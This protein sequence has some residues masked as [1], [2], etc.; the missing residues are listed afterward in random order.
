MTSFYDWYADLPVASPQVFGD[1]T[2]VPESGDWWDATYLMMWGSNVP[3]T[4]TP[5]AHWMAEVRYRGT[6][7]VTR[8]PGLRRQHQVRRRVDARAGRHRRRARD[9]DG[10]RP[11]QAS[12][13]STAQVPFFHDY[14]RTYTDLPFLIRLDPRERDERLRPGQVPHRGRPRRRRAGRGRLEDRAAR[15][16]DRCAGRAQR[17]DGLPL[18]RVRRGPLEPRPRGVDPGALR[19]AGA[20]A[21]PVEVLLPAFDGAGRHRLGAAPRRARPTRRRAPGHDRLRPHARPVRRA[22]ATGCPGSGRPGTTTS[23]RPT[24]RPGRRRSPASP[25]E[26]CIRIAREFAD[27]RRGVPGALDDHHGRRHLPVVPRRRDLPRDPRAAHPHRVH[28]PQRR[29]LGALRRPGEVPADHRLDLAR[30]RARLEPAAAHDDRH[31][32]TGTCTPTSGATTATRPTRSPHRWPRATWPACTPRTPSR[33]PRGW[34]GCRSTRSSPRTRWSSP[35]TR[36]RPSTRARPPAPRHTSPSALRDG[37][38]A[39]RPSRTSTPRRTGRARWCSGGRNLHGLLGQGQRVLPASTCSAP[40]RNVMGS[41]NPAAPRPSEVVW[42]RRGPGGQA[43][44]AASP[45]TSG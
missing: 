1:Q 35:R 29:R 14:V 12:T 38:P 41:E 27:E 39:A 19:C 28:G 33:S 2:D 34:A 17:L 15:R 8:Q 22:T 20:D 43:R 26:Q 30:Q 18:R 25:A 13:S 42:Q 9:G 40:T 23:P 32:R 24:P 21:E 37:T 44:P 4:R 45:P 10:S 3:V 5:D 7:V 16:G 36:R 6:K 11:P 31:R